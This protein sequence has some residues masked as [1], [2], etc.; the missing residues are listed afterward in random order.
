[1]SQRFYKL[2]RRRRD[3]TLGPLFIN[4]QQVI[5][6]GDWLPA[7]DHP[8]KGF[9]HRPGWHVAF[10]PKAPHLSM[11]GRVWHEVEVRDYTLLKRPACQGGVWVLAKW[12]RV[13]PD[14][15]PKVQIPE[16]NQLT[17]LA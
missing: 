13:L 15:N 9:A 4:R 3:G 17:L 6:P 8:T 10:E 12:M 1:V 5:C 11:T 7:E 14:E 16:G 2:F